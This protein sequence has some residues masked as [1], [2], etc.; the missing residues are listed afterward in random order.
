MD[1]I[2]C[3]QC[4]HVGPAGSTTPGSI[5]IELVLW[6]A[7]ILPGV[8]YSLWRINKRHPVCP[9]CANAA[10]IPAESFLGHQFIATH[11]PELL[12]S[13]TPRTRPPAKSAINVGRT[14]GRLTAKLFK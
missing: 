14:L 10:I 7:F 13:A 11:R 1:N 6:L 5:R 2:V 3:T 12:T 4:G 8:I 9:I